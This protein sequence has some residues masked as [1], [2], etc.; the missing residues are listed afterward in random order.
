MMPPAV[1][2]T[3]QWRDVLVAQLRA[4]RIALRWP[5]RI[6]VALAVLA[7]LLIGAEAVGNKEVFTFHPEHYTL[8][9]LLGALLPIA[10][11]KDEDRFGA[12]FLWTLPVDR[13]RHALIKVSA[14]WVWLMGAVALYEL[15]LLAI[16]LVSGATPFTEETRPL[17]RSFSYNMTFDASA[18]QNVRWTPEPLLWLVPFTGA[19]GTY[20]LASALALGTRH[21]LRWIAGSIPGFFLFA[22]VVA[23]LA[24]LGDNGIDRVLNAVVNGRYGI[25]ALLTARTESLQVGAPLTTGDRVIVW[26]AF[27]DV[28]HWAIATLLW[29]G[30]G[31]VAL[32]AAAARHREQRRN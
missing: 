25:D 22:F 28:E 15:W 4:V 10:V 9:G 17:L 5:T 16:T 21:P 19:T 7:S 24:D 6:A 31:L 11:W 27:P 2:G 23:H 26:W 12:A 18:I 8:P 14:G 13:F 3:P 29:N 20:V 1:H 30:A 32:V